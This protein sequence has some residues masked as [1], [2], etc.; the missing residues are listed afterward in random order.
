[1]LFSP[2]LGSPVVPTVTPVAPFSTAVFQDTTRQTTTLTCILCS[3]G[4]AP[5]QI[6]VQ[7]QVISCKTIKQFQKAD[8][9]QGGGKYPLIS[10]G[11]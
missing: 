11:R 1:M 6:A 5:A 2:E 9:A 3:L 7:T 4:Y 8:C 10:T